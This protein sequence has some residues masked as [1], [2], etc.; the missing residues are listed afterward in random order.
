LNYYIVS[1]LVSG[2]IFSVVFSE[3]GN[4]WELRHPNSNSVHTDYLI[5]L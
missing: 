4:E 5:K 2:N 1:T 3:G